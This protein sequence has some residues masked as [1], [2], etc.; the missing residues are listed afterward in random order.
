MF[1]GALVLL[2]IAFV[3]WGGSR[4]MQEIS[5]EAAEDQRYMR[6]RRIEQMKAEMRRELA[7]QEERAQR[8]RRGS[9]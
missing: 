2:L 3:A 8:E 1:F 6:E 5:E 7:E 4:R 9:Y